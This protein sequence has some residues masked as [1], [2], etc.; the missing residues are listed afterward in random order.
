[1]VSALVFSCDGSCSD[2]PYRI[3]FTSAACKLGSNNKIADKRLWATKHGGTGPQAAELIGI[4]LVLDMIW[5]DQEAQNNSSVQHKEN[6]AL[7]K[8]SKH[9]YQQ[10]QLAAILLRGSNQV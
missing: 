10:E 6:A 7:C 5:Y 2:Y 3:G 4:Y 8:G 1:M 9:A